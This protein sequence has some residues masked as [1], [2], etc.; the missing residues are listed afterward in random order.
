MLDEP[1][2]GVAPA[3]RDSFKKLLPNL[4]AR[5]QTVFFIEHDMDFVRSV[6]DHVIVMEGGAV[7]TQGTPAQVLNDSRVLDA[8]LG[9]QL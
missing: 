4:K 1:V 3:L 6:A 9:E 7:L 2:A 5:G 8:Y